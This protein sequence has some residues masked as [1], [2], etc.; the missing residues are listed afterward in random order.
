MVAQPQQSLCMAQRAATLYRQ[1][2]DMRG[3]ARA[4]RRYGYS[5]YRLGRHDEAAR[6]YGEALAIARE[7]GALVTSACLICHQ[8]EI[9]DLTDPQKR[10]ALLSEA[11]ALFERLG[12]EHGRAYALAYLGEAAFLA[13]DAA[14]AL[15]YGREVLAVNERLND[16][17]NVGSGWCDIAGYYCGLGRMEEARR[18]ACEAIAIGHR[19]STLGCIALG[20]Q[21]LAAVVAS[22]GDVLLAARL[23][24]A[25]DAQLARLSQPRYAGAQLLYDRTLDVLQAALDE[26]SLQ[27]AR[28]EG[29]GW[30]LE[31]AVEEA[32]HVP[33]QGLPLAGA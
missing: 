1:I 20:L 32:L 14:C 21:H 28:R 17:V 22:G 31:R 2:G 33:C 26:Q 9:V 16:R 24:G 27:R 13:G 6:A 29:F 8:A 10:R 18:A 12:S 5:A 3:L 11:L 23:L 7:R 15:E 30:S 25:S 4:L 19:T